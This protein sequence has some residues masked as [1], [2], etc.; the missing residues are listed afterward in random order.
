MRPTALLLTFLML[1][2]PMAGCISSEEPPAP[3]V[4]DEVLDGVWVTGGDGLPVDVEPFDTTYY[5]NDVGQQGPEPSIGVTSSGCIFFIALEKVMRSCD[6]GETWV[7]TVEG[8]VTQAPSTSDPWGWVDPL[9]DRIFNVQM[10]GLATTW[11][12]WSD[13][14]GETWLGN[15]H[16]SGPVPLNDHIK[17]ATGPWTD[18]GYGAIGSP[19]YD[20]AVYFCYNKLAGI[21]CYTSLDGGATFAVGGQAF[22]LVTTNGGL[23]GAISSAPDG[24]V[25]VPPRVATPTLVVSKDNGLNWEEKTMGEDVG[26]PNP[27][28]NSEMAADTESNGYHVWTGAD[29][30]VYMSRSTDSG[31]SWEQTS[32]R[33]SPVDVVSSVFPQIIAGDPGRMAV[34]YLG[35]EDAGALGVPDIDGNPWDGNAHYATANVS[36]DLYVTYSLNALDENP[37]FQTVRVTQDPV[38]VGSICLN[39]GDCRDIGGSNR[40]LLD[41]NDIVI[42][43]EG[44]IFIAIT[45]GCTGECATKDVPTPEDSRDRL[46]TLVYLASGPSLLA[47]VGELTPLVAGNATT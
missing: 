39:S 47:D 8:D 42:D 46:G 5:I 25:Y 19:V 22:G 41:F 15:P 21:F 6:S 28:K 30:G 11:I 4:D 16:D 17:L 26:T 40:N 32:L 44:R 31:E 43:S 29:Q 18:S 10:V 33:I 36:Y 7:N 27:R 12:G 23:H 1:L 35:S 20:T 14:D 38:Q 37:V 24:T 2:A 9:T 3:V 45:D 13:D 34:A